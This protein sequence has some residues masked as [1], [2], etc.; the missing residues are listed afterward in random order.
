MRE[1]KYVSDCVFD[2]DNETCSNIW[3]VGTRTLTLRNNKPL[4][5]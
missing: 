3:N 1:F 5:M 4:H 2:V